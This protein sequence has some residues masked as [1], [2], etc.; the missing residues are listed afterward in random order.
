MRGLRPDRNP[1]RRRADRVETFIFGGLIVAALAIAPL[2]AVAASH[3]AYHSALQAAQAQRATYHRVN[4]RLVAPPATAMNGLTAS[5]IVPAR[6]QWLVPG[7]KPR[8]GQ[9]PVPAGSRKGDH[10]L[11][12]TDAA[13][14]VTSPPLTRAQAA[15]QGTFAAIMAVIATLASC[16]LLAGVTRLVVNRRRLAAWGDDWAVTAPM[17]TRQRW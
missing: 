15:D 3:G 11:I 16:L 17:W 9:I 4:A 14:T 5:S 12:W 8:T 1:L 6:A 2:G 13:G 10:I 7:G